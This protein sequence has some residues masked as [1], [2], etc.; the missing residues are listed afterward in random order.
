MVYILY[1]VHL[2][3]RQRMAKRHLV[4]EYEG[5]FALHNACIAWTECKRSFAAPCQQATGS[6][7]M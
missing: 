1:D 2:Y 5:N 3:I 6:S 7:F 4:W